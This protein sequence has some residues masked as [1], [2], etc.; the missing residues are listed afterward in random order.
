[1]FQI[2]EDLQAVLKSQKSEE[3]SSIDNPSFL[4]SFNLPI[5]NRNELQEINNFLD[6]QENFKAAVSVVIKHNF[7][8]IF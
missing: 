8:Q 5:K 1:M 4:N 2:R 6:N 7:C 3:K